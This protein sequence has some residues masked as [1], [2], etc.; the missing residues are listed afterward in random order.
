MGKML[1]L[2]G[3]KLDMDLTIMDKSQYHPGAKVCPRFVEGNFEEYDDVI[4]FGTTLDIITIE[5]EKVNVAALFELEAQGI[6]VFPQAR[7]IEIIQDKGLQKQFYEKHGLPSSKFR[8]YDDLTQLQQ[9]I[10]EAK[11]TFP[12]IQKLR[13]DGYDGRGVVLL[14]N[15]DD[16]NI[17]F[18]Q[19]FL[20]EEKIDIH[21]EIA[22]M[23]CRTQ[24]GEM[25]MYDPVE[26]VFHPTKNILLFQ[27]APA[28]VSEEQKLEL[29]SLA[30][31]TIEAFDMVG[32]LAIEMFI[33]VQGEI[34]IN[35]V[36]PRPHNSGHHTIEGCITSQYENHLRAISKLPLGSTETVM[37]S[38][39]MNVLGDEN[40]DGPVIYEGLEEILQIPGVNLHIYGKKE[41]KP[42]R[43]MGHIN[44]VD[45]DASKLKDRYEMICKHFRVISQL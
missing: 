11:V 13:K 8:L 24:D 4:R 25:K 30:K 32:L 35:E 36:A 3:A 45:A 20:I 2:A 12:F 37:P 42:F 1:Y 31:R 34:L 6:E 40:H 38:L 23:A 26:M 5:I 7:V 27:Q 22:V 17:A 28:L 39:L 18:K 19:Y 41:T 29:L 15:S 10:N 14:K 21:K 33:T 9:D 43:K 44:L 16:L